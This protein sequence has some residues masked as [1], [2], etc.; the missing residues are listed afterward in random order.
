MASAELG[1]PVFR[2]HAGCIVFVAHLP[3]HLRCS[4]LRWRWCD[5]RLPWPQARE[6]EPQQAERR[7]AAVPVSLV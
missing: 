3:S 5:A 7:S 2:R 1:V 6:R 4:L